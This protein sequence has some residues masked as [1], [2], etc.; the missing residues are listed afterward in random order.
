MLDNTSSAGGQLE[1]PSDVNNS[2]TANPDGETIA[3]AW[4]AGVATT[5]AQK[6]TTESIERAPM[7]SSICKEK[8][9]PVDHKYVP[10]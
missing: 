7:Y 5:D 2:T 1:H 8:I 6:I 9:L 3:S 10:K 4:T